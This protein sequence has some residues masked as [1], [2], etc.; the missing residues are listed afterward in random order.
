[1]VSCAQN[2]ISFFLNRFAFLGNV[3]AKFTLAP[4]ASELQNLLGKNVTFLKDCVGSEV[5][6]ACADP[7]PGSIF[8]LENL[9][10]HVEE[11][12]KG[13]DASGNKVSLLNGSKIC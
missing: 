11:E 4:V 3:N 9:R 7:S 6:S 5:E 1:M 13:V 10:Y 8:L 2:N 12:G